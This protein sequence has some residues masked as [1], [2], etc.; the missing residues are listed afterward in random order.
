MTDPGSCW[1]RSPEV[2]VIFAPLTEEGLA[3][4][5]PGER[6]IWIRS[7]LD[8]EGYRRV[9]ELANT[10][11]EVG[12]RIANRDENLEFL[13]YFETVG[14]FHVSNL[15]LKSLEGLRHLPETLESLGIDDTLTKSLALAPLARFQHLRELFLNGHRKDIQVLRELTAVERLTLRSITLPDLSLLRPLS[16][17]WWL[18]LHLGGTRDLRLLT[19]T[20]P[21]LHLELWMIRG[22]EDVSVLGS[23]GELQ[24]LHLQALRGVTALPSFAG[25][26][27][28]RRVVLETMKGLQDLSP[29][30]RAPALEQVF[31]IDMPQLD[32]EN[33]RCFVGHPT[34]REA[35]LGLGSLRK[36][37]RA[38]EIL[39]RPRP[40]PFELRH[41]GTREP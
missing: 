3:P 1:S 28:L 2:R 10:C 11:P 9:A 40:G 4:L 5:G 20:G 26:R 35:A 14:D 21:L 18:E 30:A 33:L 41:P 39:E 15:R 7:S 22:L 19:E 34:L 29:L 25:A 37:R 36:N 16:R 23:L 13:Q 12:L 27:S 6:Y 8:E 17:L 24:E 38:S 31:L 32:P